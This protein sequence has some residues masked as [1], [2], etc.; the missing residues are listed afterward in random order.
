MKKS[1]LKVRILALLLCMVMILNTSVSAFA[2]E[3]L[4]DSA[5]S[6]EEAVPEEPETE[7]VAPEEP[8]TEEAA[9]EE[10]ETEEVAPE[11]PETE[12]VAP[13]EPEKEEVVPEEPKTEEVVPEEPEIEEVAPE[14]PKT[15]EV[16]PEEPEKGE[17]ITEMTLVNSELSNMT[18]SATALFK[19][20]SSLS[21]SE[22]TEGNAFDLLK[23]KLE[24]KAKAE[25]KEILGFMAYD[26][27]LNDEDG[28]E[29]ILENEVKISAAY[30]EPALP[31]GILL[32]DLS[33][34]VLVNLGIDESGKIAAKEFGD[35]KATE[36][37]KA[38]YFEFTASS[39]FEFAVVWL[40][41]PKPVVYHYED[42]QVIVD[43]TAPTKDIFPEGAE[44]SVTPIIEED[45]ETKDQ[46]AE[47]AEKLREQV[48]KE[49]K[50]VAGFL[51][52]DI[53][54]VD[55]VTGAKV[56]PQGEVTVSMNYKEAA[57]PEAVRE[58]GPENT[59]VS[60][61]HLEEDADGAV[62][63]VVDMT[64]EQDQPAVL[65]VT[66]ENQVQA[67]ELTTDSFSVFTITWEYSYK[68]E[69]S[70]TAHY[71]YLNDEGEFAPIPNVEGIENIEFTDDIIN[72]DQYGKAK[73][74]EGY[75]YFDTT[76][77]RAEGESVNALKKE[78]RGNYIK[79]YSIKYRK[80]DSEEF[81]AWLSSSSYQGQS[82][83]DI[84][85][86]YKKNV[87]SDGGTGDSGS[88][89]ELAH[90]KY[91]KDNKDGTYD[92]TLDVVGAAGTKT[93][94][95]RVDVLFIVDKSGSMKRTMT[96]NDEARDEK[97]SRI[98]KLNQAITSAIDKL[99][100][101]ENVIA[102]YAM[103]NFETD[104]SIKQ[105]WTTN[106]EKIKGKLDSRAEGGT[107]Y[108]D[109][110]KKAKKLL[111]WVEGDS[112]RKIV[113]F[114]TDGDCG[115]YNKPD[116]EVAG[117]GNSFN[118]TA[119]K[120]ANQ[121]LSI[122]SNMNDFYTVGV[123]PKSSYTHL[124]EFNRVPDGVNYQSFVGDS[125]NNLAGVFETIIG[126]ITNI[127]A[128]N[129]QIEDTL[130]AHVDRVPNTA[131]VVKIVNGE[132]QDVTEQ[133]LEKSGVHSSYDNENKKLELMFGSDYQ[134]ADDYTYSVTIKIQPNEAARELYKTNG[135]QYPHTGDLNTDADGNATSSGKPGIFS[136]TERGAILKYDVKEGEKLEK[137]ELSYP[138]PVVQIQDPPTEQKK[139]RVNFYLN[140]NSQILDTDGNINNQGVENFTKSVSGDRS[141]LGG[142]LHQDLWVIVPEDHEHGTPK[143]LGVIGSVSDQNASEVDAQIRKLGT[144]T[145]ASGNQAGQEDK[146]YYIVDGEDRSVFPNDGE[147]FEYIR[148]NW[149]EAENQG[150]NKG[151]DI[152]VNNKPINPNNLTEE[153]FAIRWYVFKDN[154]DDYWHVDG[155]LVPKSGI[156][157]ITKTFPNEQIADELKDTF[158]IQ[159]TGDFLAE[160]ETTISNTLSDKEVEITKNGDGTITYLW[161]MAVFGNKYKITETGYE[162]TTTSV[163]R[164]SGT[165]WSYT[166]AEG[167]KNTGITTETR[168]PTQHSASDMGEPVKQRL[169]FIN[170][171]T[172]SL[173]LEK[174]SKG[175]DQPIAGAEFR[176]SKK[177]GVP[178][179]EVVQEKISVINSDPENPELNNLELRALY[180]LEE[181]RAP[182]AHSLLV[183]PIYF[184]VVDGTVEFCDENGNPATQPEMVKL[185]NE[186][187]KIT[188]IVKNEILYE[189]PSTG[190]SGIYLTMAGGLAMMMGA[191]YVWFKAKR[192]ETL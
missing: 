123:G 124:K 83:G 176:L 181:T 34:I 184:K 117:S 190:G 7:E 66:E 128:V 74:I 152:L 155:I 85:F 175:N 82:K 19:E 136:N 26:F 75:T 3:T 141:T 58:I 144:E 189:L 132:G 80:T 142:G 164:Y 59:T 186:P 96:S 79:S 192:E 111:A 13:E 121:T 160:T 178:D 97:N 157:E 99:K 103:V 18:L 20:G 65:S 67:V 140:L 12:E 187:G 45:K 68:S 146:T 138:K 113:V 8:E 38:A 30:E 171:Y 9:P 147:I 28:N 5:V 92:L 127:N 151:K 137:K 42:D 105:Y 183:E 76:V 126:S 71:V 139:E 163:Y 102:R 119:L 158:A 188:L 167:E 24:E 6:S 10:P 165:S 93:N 60:V 185:R 54:F 78:E 56:E 50:D 91:V 170:T 39:G 84:Y 64:A 131:P 90:R 154:Y 73:S 115:Y 145:G 191:A 114:L 174:Y 17:E 48:A 98:Y 44:L 107:N 46:Y 134:L 108:Q 15:E 135:Y 156:L 88:S 63:Q 51:A 52:Y 21:V 36:E 179:W 61:H 25:D 81:S 14:E 43:V 47:V 89:M 125:V 106:S 86:C 2:T 168:V 23:E 112:T 109:A 29:L 118:E 70:V 1:N 148:N 172:V 129:V 57:I 35:V 11:E 130:T 153:N 31:E 122:M 104:A 101:K 173:D 72:L 77:D 166:D 55:P 4:E 120:Y 162:T 159:V 41:E 16:V 69:L 161:S 53:K 33:D 40:G 169:D 94:P 32:E 180:K 143:V 150:V 87:S 22:L 116:G 100:S 133:E 95:A 27:S 110:L 182:E 37:G 149:S 62:Q 49:E 177:A